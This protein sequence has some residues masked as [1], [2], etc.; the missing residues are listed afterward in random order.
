[1]ESKPDPKSF[2]RLTISV[3]KLPA[4]MAQA[5]AT[6]SYAAERAKLLLG[7]YRTGDAN[8][9]ATYVAAIAAT[10]AHY[11]EDIITRVTHPVTGLPSRNKWLPS[12]NEVREA[13]D[14]AIEPIVEKQRR[15]Q[16]VE[17]QL[18]E[19][20][21]IDEDRARRRPTYDDL[22]ARYGENFGLGAVEEEARAASA[23]PAPT[24]EQLRHHYAHYKLGFRPKH[25]DAQ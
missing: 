14:D 8:D 4:S 5:E 7:C 20:R 17:Q 21:K 12:V 24:A 11:P 13:C 16:R 1:M 6:A 25:E 15:Q 3:E 22:K 18:E 9:P 19:R 23:T 10:L 2:K